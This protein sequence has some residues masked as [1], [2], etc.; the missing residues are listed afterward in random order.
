MS[1]VFKKVKRVVKKVVSGV[2]NVVKTVAKSPVFKAIAVA[3][4]VYFTGGAALGAASGISSGAGALSGAMSGVANAWSG[5]TGAG[6]ALLS[7]DLAGAGS[8]LTK[9]ITG[10]YGKGAGL[11]AKGA[12][13][14]AGQSYQ[15]AAQILNAS[16]APKGIPG[17][18]SG[19]PWQAPAGVPGGLSGPSGVVDPAKGAAANG[20]LLQAMAPMA[21]Y[22]GGQMLSGMAAQKAAEE[23][24]KEERD[25]INGNMGTPL[26]QGADKPAERTYGTRGPTY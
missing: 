24:A 16:D 14:G 25:R 19:A 13:T 11:L 2:A 6:S 21:V 9:G 1:K 7:G 4:A 23:Q 10:A 5:I 22:T 8:S 15:S 12:A 20:G 3:A 17:L 18:P 26:W